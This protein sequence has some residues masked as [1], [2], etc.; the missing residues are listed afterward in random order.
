MGVLYIVLHPRIITLEQQLWCAEEKI[1]MQIPTRKNTKKSD[2]NGRPIPAAIIKYT[3]Y[4][5][6]G[7]ETNPIIRNFYPRPHPQ[8]ILKLAPSPNMCS[9]TNDTILDS[10]IRPNANP[11]PNDGIFQ[12]RPRLDCHSIKHHDIPPPLQCLDQ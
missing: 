8:P 10:S 2:K 11:M 1:C 9:F 3:T 4:L 7:A 5:R 12:H 6:V